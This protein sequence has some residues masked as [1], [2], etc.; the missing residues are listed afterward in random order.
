MK[1]LIASL[2]VAVGATAIVAGAAGTASAETRIP[3]KTGLNS[4]WECLEWIFD[5]ANPHAM[6]ECQ[7]G[8][9]GWAVIW[10]VE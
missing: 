10:L 5:N 9:G 4:E 8:Y 1:K 3:L 2:A 7:D 6:Y